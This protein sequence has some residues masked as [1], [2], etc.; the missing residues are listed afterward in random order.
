MSKAENK[1]EVG[2]A[3]E[4]NSSNNNHRVVKESGCSCILL[5]LSVTLPLG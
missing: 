5:L 1:E 3:P 2:K 4:D